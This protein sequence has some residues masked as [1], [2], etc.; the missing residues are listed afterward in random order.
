VEDDCTADGT[1]TIDVRADG[2]TAV[3]DSTGGDESRAGGGEGK[4]GSDGGECEAVANGGAVAIGD[5]N[6]GG[7]AGEAER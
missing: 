7:N 3:C 2:G 4:R 1:C 5:I 6:S